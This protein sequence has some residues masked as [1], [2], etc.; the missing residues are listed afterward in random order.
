MSVFSINV[1]NSW[2]LEG[3]LQKVSRVL[4][5]RRRLYSNLT[6]DTATDWQ[7]IDTNF[8]STIPQNLA[9]TLVGIQKLSSP[10]YL[11]VFEGKKK[12][13]AHKWGF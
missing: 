4:Q 3:I 5:S 1:K 7:S 9:Y 10:E 6:K 8:S 13:D 12:K 11:H 2:A